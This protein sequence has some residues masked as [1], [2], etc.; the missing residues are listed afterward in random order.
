MTNNGQFVR[1]LLFLGYGFVASAVAARTVGTRRL[2]ATTRRESRAGDMRAAGIE[3]IIVSDLSTTGDE[4]PSDG[5]DV[6]ASFPPD[7]FTDAALAPRCA[8]AHR[9]VYISSTAVYGTTAGVVDDATPARAT[10]FRSEL[11]LGAESAW[12]SVGAIVL[13]APGIYGPGQGLHVALG[14]GTYRLP[15]DGANVL[16][17]IHVDDLASIALAALDRGRPGETYVVGD[18][19]P[20]PQREVVVWL[21]ER[22]SLPLPPAAPLE[23]VPATM[24]GNRS[25][26]GSR[27]LADLGVTLRYPTFREGFDALLRPSSP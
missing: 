15:G 1:P 6:L 9:I 24:R 7:G 25:V 12:R 26:D 4:L 20:T 13:R 27:V 8:G 3:P 22:L 21:C 18:D 10:D 5:A 14:N 16:S 17:R 2:F 11:R 19:A 23:T